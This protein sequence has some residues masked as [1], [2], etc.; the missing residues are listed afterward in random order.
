MSDR[1]DVVVAHG[2][3]VIDR[4]SALAQAL[5]AQG[6]RVGLGEVLTAHQALTAVDAT[7]ARRCET[8]A[9][10]RAVRQPPRHRALRA[11]VPGRVRRRADA[12]RTGPVTSRS[13]RSSGRCRRAPRWRAPRPPARRSGS[14]GRAGRLQR[15]RA[16][17]PQGLLAVHRRGD[18]DRPRADRPARAARARRA[19]RAA[20]ARP[21]A[22]VTRPTCAA[23]SVLRFAPPASPCSA[24]GARR[25]RVRGRLSWCATCRAR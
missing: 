16:A 21:G 25:A 12:L 19:C 13:A 9:A 7:L 3:I 8:C 1:G 22:A 11:S 15:R 2:D 24:T 17:R 14:G 5:R 4:L 23:W 18:G 20:R 10:Q 6:T